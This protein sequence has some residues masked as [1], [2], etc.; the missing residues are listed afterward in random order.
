MN[1]I[2]FF[3]GFLIRKEKVSGIGISPILLPDAQSHFFTGVKTWISGWK[4]VGAQSKPRHCHEEHI[5]LFI[6][7]FLN[8]FLYSRFLLVT[9]F[10]HI[11]VYMSIPTS[12]F[13]TAHP[14]CPT[15]FPLGVHEFVLFICVS[16]FALQTRSSVP[17]F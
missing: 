1:R 3:K 7:I 15:A 13:I 8:F 9:H 6:F 5:S 12:E 2:E 4:R 17:F 14:S 16:I 10:I 11:S